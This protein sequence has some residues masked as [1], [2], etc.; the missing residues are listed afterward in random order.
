MFIDV[1]VAAAMARS[2]APSPE[3]RPDKQVATDK[4]GTE[5]LSCEAATVQE[6]SGK[7]IVVGG[8]SLR[9]T[10]S[11]LERIGRDSRKVLPKAK[12]GL[13]SRKMDIKEKTTMEWK[14]KPSSGK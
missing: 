5:P 11:R 10:K 9:G 3:P 1:A 4:G 14:I 8:R 6:V 2:R 13:R 7:T 12:T